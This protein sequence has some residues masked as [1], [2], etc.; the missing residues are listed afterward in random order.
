MLIRSAKNA[1]RK[2]QK[3]G[4][5]KI[6]NIG[7]NIVPDDGKNVIKILKMLKEKN[8]IREKKQRMLYAR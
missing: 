1:E 4:I 3:D 5:E 7:M 8:G 2:H 6:K